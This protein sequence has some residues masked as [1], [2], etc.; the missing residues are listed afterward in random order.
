MHAFH[1]IRYNFGSLQELISNHL[2]LKE[3]QRTQQ[4]QQS[5]SV[6]ICRTIHSQKW[7]IYD[8]I[9]LNENAPFVW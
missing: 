3:M 6:G 1:L 4:Y 9:N 2:E 7:D 8:E 5:V